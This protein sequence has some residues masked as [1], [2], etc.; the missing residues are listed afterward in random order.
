MNRVYLRK[1]IV[2]AIAKKSGFSQAVCSDILNAYHNLMVEVVENADRM[3]DFGY[4]TL[5]T[6][7]VPEHFRGNPQD[8]SI[9]V[10]VQD[11]YKVK[12]TVG[13]TLKDASERTIKNVNK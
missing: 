9:K 10:K 13:K 6:K 8:N 1:D 4:F 11:K 7:F 3:E 5:E 12:I 2:R